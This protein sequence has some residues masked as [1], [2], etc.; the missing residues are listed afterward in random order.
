MKALCL[1]ATLV[2][3][4]TASALNLFLGGLWVAAFLTVALLGRRIR[5][6]G[7]LVLA[8]TLAA[9][10]A[11]WPFPWSRAPA[12]TSYA[13]DER[14]GLGALL[15]PR[16]GVGRKPEGPEN[17]HTGLALMARLERR[18]VEETRYS[19]GDLER[20]AAAVVAASRELGPLRDRAPAEILAVEQAVRRLALT[21]TAPEFRDLDGRR[22]RLLAWLSD[23]ETRIRAA[24]DETELTDMGRALEPATMAPVSFRALHEDFERVNAGMVALVRAITR[25]SVAVTAVSRIEYDEARGR[26]L[27]EERYTLSA[28]S[29]LGIRRLEVGMLRRRATERGLEQTLAYRIA[30]GEPRELAGATEV[31]LTPPAGRVV[32]V[33]RRAGALT[34][35]PVRSALKTIAFSRLVVEPAPG[36]PPELA[37]TVALDGASGSGVPLSIEPPAPRLEGLILPRHS[38]H[39]VNAPG[40]L[41]ED[42]LHD[43]WVPTDTESLVRAVQVELV[44]STIL[45]RNPVFAAL[46]AYLYVPTVHASLVLTGLAAVAL[47]LVA[48]P[49]G[50][51]PAAATLGRR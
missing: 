24:R 36:P 38:L 31:V 8:V 12:P 40:A 27:R 51:A 28:D 17:S 10:A 47:I 15:S 25:R 43:A 22:A 7:W 34:L 32:V 4:F 30:D 37:V 48:R 3:V 14:A 5:Y 20:R 1:S 21:L 29:P 23:V 44:P 6:A 49:R 26:L 9:G 2:I 16:A 42:G 46:K 19:T 45:L 41:T 50:A 39:H 13:V 35:V 11:V 33:D 18:R